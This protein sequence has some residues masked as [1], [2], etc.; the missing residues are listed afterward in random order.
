MYFW[1]EYLFMVLLSTYAKLL[2]HISG[3]G[4][5]QKDSRKPFHHE[6]R[7]QT[8]CSQLVPSN[9]LHVFGHH[10]ASLLAPLRIAFISLSGA[11]WFG[12]ESNSHAA[13]RLKMLLSNP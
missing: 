12:I 7:R 5:I 9:F 4:T 1:H 13:N 6:M 10:F 3:Y 11:S 2:F 8:A